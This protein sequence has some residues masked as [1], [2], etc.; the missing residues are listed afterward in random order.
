MAEEFKVVLTKK[1]EAELDA[2]LSYHLRN[3][4][5]N[6][7]RKA[8][9]AINQKFTAIEIMPTA[10]PLYAP[11]NREFKRKYRYTIARKVYRILYTIVVEKEVVR[12]ITI[13]NVK[14]DPGLMIQTVEEE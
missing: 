11:K 1:A 9:E 8:Y 13:R 2:I 10:F 3:Y 7:A 6:A 4:G 12:I 5:E 14:A